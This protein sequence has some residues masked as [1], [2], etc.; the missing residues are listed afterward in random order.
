MSM[1]WALAIAALINVVGHVWAWRNLPRNTALLVS[2]WIL[3]VTIFLVVLLVHAI[4]VIV[5]LALAAV[6][7]ALFLAAH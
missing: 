7:L 5:V 3:L 4:W 6:V 1:Q 2:A